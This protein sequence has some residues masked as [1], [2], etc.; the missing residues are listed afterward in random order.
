MKMNV[1]LK[2][3]KGFRVHIKIKPNTKNATV[4]FPVWLTRM[5]SIQK[6]APTV[7][8]SMSGVRAS[9]QTVIVYQ[10]KYDNGFCRD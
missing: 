1:F 8:E 6:E 10:M 9:K 7:T 4:W 2:F 5:T 3:G